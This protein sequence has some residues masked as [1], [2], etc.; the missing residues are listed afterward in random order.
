MILKIGYQDFLIKNETAALQAVK[1]LAGAIP[2]GSRHMK[3]GEIYEEFFWPKDRENKVTIE[4][5]TERQIL[6][7]DPEEMKPVVTCRL[8]LGPGGER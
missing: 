5:I 8:E 4:M 6:R 7:A 2:M 1:A 3:R